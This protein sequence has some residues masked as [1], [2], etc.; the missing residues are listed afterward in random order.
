MNHVEFQEQVARLKAAFSE[1]DFTN[2]KL[3]LIWPVVKEMPARFFTKQMDN[4][5]GNLRRAPLLDDFKRIRKLWEFSIQGNK[6]I[7]IPSEEIPPERMEQNKAA[8]REMMALLNRK[9]AGEI[10]HDELRWYLKNVIFKGLDLKR[11]C[12]RQG[13]KLV[14]EY[15]T[16]NEYVFKCSCPKG[17]LLQEPYPIWRQNL[18]TRYYD[19]AD[20]LWERD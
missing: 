13:Y 3:D 14:R 5:I 1:K 8:I 10:S 11:Y 7:E 2:P 18:E 20:W 12:C 9:L 15:D 19:E 17:S 16:Q 6:Q 4:F